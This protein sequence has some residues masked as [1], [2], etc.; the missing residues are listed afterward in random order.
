MGEAKRRK[1]L[2]PSYGVDNFKLKFLS[3]EE[4]ETIV[5]KK[6]KDFVA[7]QN[8]KYYF[9][10]LIAEEVT[11]TGVGLTFLVGTEVN[12]KCVWQNTEDISIELQNRIIN[13]HL[14]KVVKKIAL[15][16][17]SDVDNALKK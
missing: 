17:K 7:K 15:K 16:L 4:S 11:I 14:K 2:D 6:L 5:R 9:V 13:K 12:V 10:Q 1:K 8:Y 3:K